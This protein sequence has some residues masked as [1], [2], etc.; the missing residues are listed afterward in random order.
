MKPSAKEE[1]SRYDI[2]VRSRCRWGLKKNPPV[3]FREPILT[4][5]TGFIQF[6]D[7]L[8][9][10]SIKKAPL[11]EQDFA[12]GDYFNLFYNFTL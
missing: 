9:G 10:T 12:N 1:I 11:E 2:A 3:S 4:F 7:E 6:K 5:I 8:L